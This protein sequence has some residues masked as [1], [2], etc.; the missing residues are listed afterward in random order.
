MPGTKGKGQ[1]S[2]LERECI[3]KGIMR[4]DTI[5]GIARKLGRSPST[6]ER[7]IKRNGTDAPRRKL[8]VMTRNICV[9]RDTCHRVDLCKKGCLIPCFRCRES[10]C[11]RLC[12]DFEGKPCPRLER[13]P[14][15]CNGCG[16]IYGYGC[17]HPYHFYEA[18]AAHEKATSRKKTARM[19]IDC[20]PEELAA[21]ISI[22]E[23]GVKR[24]QSIRHIFAT[25]QGRT[26]CS[27]RTFYDYVEAGI[28]AE[29]K[30]YDLPRKV[31]FKPRKKSKP[32]GR[33]IPR[34]ALI[35]RT[36]EDFLK[37]SDQQRMSAVEMDCVVGRRGTD[38]KAI[39]TL[40]FRRTNFQLMLLLDEKTSSNVIDAIDMLEDLCGELFPK[41]FPV[42]L[43]DRGSEFENPERLEHS[44][45]AKPR[46]KIYY[47]DP[48]QSQQKPQCEK[49]CV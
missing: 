31:R 3:E 23:S 10:L 43:C 25:N 16:E 47:C 27:W 22:V 1:L 45:N 32:K 19:G 42:I 29:I 40:L 36:Y 26:C 20:A 15:C 4:K 9:H 46:T 49:L 24:G 35:G 17:A 39:L 6:I 18:E 14:Y 7:E 44:R 30:N 38:K 8:A 2:Y 11:N 34:E 41:I 33:G 48:Q 21:T 37:L 5:S 12:P 28:I 13:P